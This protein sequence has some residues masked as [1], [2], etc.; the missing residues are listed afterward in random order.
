MQFQ[1]KSQGDFFS[2]NDS[3][4]SI[5][6]NTLKKKDTIRYETDLKVKNRAFIKIQYVIKCGISNR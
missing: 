5:S 3:F 2:T 4:H 1:L 6:K